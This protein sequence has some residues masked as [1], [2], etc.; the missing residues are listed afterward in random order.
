MPKLQ[1]YY[2]DFL[3]RAEVARI[4][5]EL[6][7]VEYEDVRLSRDQWAEFKPKTPYGQ[8]P[9]MTV[10]GKM[11]AQSA[12]IS[13]YCAKLAGLVPSNDLQAALCDELYEA[14]SEIQALVYPS[15]MMKDESEKLEARKKLVEGPL[16]DKLAM[17]DKRLADIAGDK[18][19]GGDKPSHGDLAVYCM[20]GWL[21]SG[22][23]DGIPKDLLKSYSN[24][25]A[26]RNRVASVPVIKARYEG[27]EDA[28]SKAMMP[29]AA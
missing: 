12:A 4:A 9:V 28:M 7:G 23:L 18:F 20:C 22:T 5:L 3:G 8:L 14:S 10:D 27:K 26:L 21:I 6:S 15:M 13:R 17:L 19:V 25:S 1:L 29:S 24:L 16:A 11:L 2:F